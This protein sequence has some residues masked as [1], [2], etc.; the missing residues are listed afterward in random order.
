MAV[1]KRVATQY[2]KVI[3]TPHHV[4][5]IDPWKWLHELLSC[6]FCVAV[7]LSLGAT[8]IYRPYVLSYWRPLDFIV[9]ALAIATTSMLGVLIIRKAV[10]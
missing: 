1:A 3:M 2:I 10:Q 5:V 4:N 8:G 7:W 9:T 6:P